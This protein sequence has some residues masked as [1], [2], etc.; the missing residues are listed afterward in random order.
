MKSV[1]RIDKSSYLMYIVMMFV[2]MGCVM[3]CSQKKEANEGTIAKTV[4]TIPYT[5]KQM[6]MISTSQRNA[7]NKAYTEEIWSSSMD[8][9]GHTYD[10]VFEAQMKEFFIRLYVMSMSAQSRGLIL[11]D[12]ENEAVL[13]LSNEYL[14]EAAKSDT[15]LKDI[16]FDEVNMMF[17][18]YAL[19]NKLSKAVIMSKELEVSENEARIMD[20]EYIVLNDR[21]KAESVLAEVTAEGAD[22][23]SI[24][25]KASTE[26][27]IKIKASHDDLPKEADKQV[28]LL[29]DSEISDIIEAEGKYYIYKCILGYDEAATAERKEAMEKSRRDE[30]LNK[31]YD[32]YM[33]SSNIALNS[34]E[35]NKFVQDEQTTFE[36]ADFFA[37]YNKEFKLLK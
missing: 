1:S 23:A 27:E 26:A 13:K 14:A 20:L 22:F 17:R 10:E 25:R 4:V 2:C 35:W 11:T 7:V 34:E 37:A 29:S 12:K 32:E 5:E 24:A 33:E 8:K 30:A 36:G 9:E 15:K 6:L 18:D 16:T 19:A 28:S 3:S 31:I 21:E